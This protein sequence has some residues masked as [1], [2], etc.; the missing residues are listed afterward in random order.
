[1][2]RWPHQYIVSGR[3]EFPRD[4]L[5]YDE[6]DYATL[7]DERRAGKAR[8]RRS[9]RIHGNVEPS[10]ERWESFGWRV[11][12]VE[13]LPRQERADPSVAEGRP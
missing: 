10:P 4:M 13:P 1:M 3:G 7:A 12:N 2:F 6:A 8:E 11:S 9:I 5:R